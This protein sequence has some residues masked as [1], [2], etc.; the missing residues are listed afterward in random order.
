MPTPDII[1]YETIDTSLFKKRRREKMPALPMKKRVS[2]FKEVELGFDELRASCEA[3]RCFGCGM[4]P[5]K[6]E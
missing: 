2:R 6:E 1:L 4:F 3:D 5:K